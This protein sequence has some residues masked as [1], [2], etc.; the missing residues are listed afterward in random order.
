MVLRAGLALFLL[1]FLGSICS[2]LAYS[3]SQV[4][5]Q[6]TQSE[7]LSTEIEVENGF[8]VHQSPSKKVHYTKDRLAWKE[9]P[10]LMK[11]SLVEQQGAEL[12]FAGAFPMGEP[13]KTFDTIDTKFAK[14]MSLSKLQFQ[15][16]RTLLLFRA[17]FK[18]TNLTDDE[19]VK[20]LEQEL[21]EQPSESE[22]QMMNDSSDWRKR[23]TLLRLYFTLLVDSAE[24][25][26]AFVKSPNESFFS[27]LQAA[28]TKSSPTDEAAK[29]Q[30]S[31]VKWE[32]D[33]L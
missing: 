30:R 23:A 10:A 7:Q 25:R 20:L 8:E 18:L 15:L 4:A 17:S 13:Q 22:I 6:H 12:A 1:V 33:A 27:S 28:A 29:T 26:R 9:L 5:G 16:Q 31:V 19:V 2:K 3:R 32:F 14:Q 21:K 24:L 11:R